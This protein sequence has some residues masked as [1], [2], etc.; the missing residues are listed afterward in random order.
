MSRVDEILDF[1][2]G[3][4]A[5][6]GTF[7]DVWFEKNED[8]DREISSRFRKDYER[9]AAGG[10][11][12]WQNSERGCLALILLL[13]Q[14]PRNMFRGDARAFATDHR[15]RAVADHAVSEG[16]DLALPPIQRMFVYLPF[17]HSE[18]TEDQQRS[19]ELFLALDEELDGPDLVSYARR[20]AEIISRF[21]RFP[22]RN[23]TLGRDTTP[24]EAEFLEEPGSSF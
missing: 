4:E 13:D 18:D 14:F 2:F 20:H 1:W 21:G 17:E 12:D 9:A 5:E 16:M 7:R 10:L 3:G 6:R 22:H 8:F 19:I 23:A 11:E 24:E 15:A